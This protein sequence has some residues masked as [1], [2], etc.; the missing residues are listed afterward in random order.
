MNK[1]IYSGIVYSSSCDPQ[2]EVVYESTRDDHEM[3]NIEVDEPIMQRIQNEH[4]RVKQEHAEDSI[5]PLYTEDYLETT[6]RR[7]SPTKKQ[8]TH[9]ECCYNELHFIWT[10]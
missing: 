1:C 2:E 7:K 8:S 4:T 3:D 6:Q 5:D 9:G 10:K